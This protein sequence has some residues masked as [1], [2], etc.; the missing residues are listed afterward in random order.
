MNRRSFITRAGLLVGSIGVAD[1]FKL[2]LMGRLGRS[3]VPQAQAESLLAG[4]LIDVCFRSG[5]PMM[6][7]TSFSC[8]VDVSM[9]IGLKA[10]SMI[11]LGSFFCESV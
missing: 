4:R 6:S 1:S 2:D 9:S 11:C 7:I 3:L 10:P 5:F 8:Y